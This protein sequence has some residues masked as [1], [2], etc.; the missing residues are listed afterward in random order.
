MHRMR[1][2]KQTA[3]R[4]RLKQDSKLHAKEREIGALLNK[5]F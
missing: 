1:L 5:V 3:E 2:D 4:E